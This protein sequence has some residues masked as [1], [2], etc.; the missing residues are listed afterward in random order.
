MDKFP[1]TRNMWNHWLCLHPRTNRASLKEYWGLWKRLGHFYV[2]KPLFLSIWNDFVPFN[3]VSIKQVFTTESSRPATWCE[4]N[5]SY[6]KSRS[7]TK[8]TERE[9]RNCRPPMYFMGGKWQKVR[10]NCHGNRVGKTV[11]IQSFEDLGYFTIDNMPTALL[12]N[13]SSLCAASPDNTQ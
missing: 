2:V 13:L 11:A 8:K 9:S 1:V 7:K 5:W 10:F 4:G 12:L 3:E 6:R